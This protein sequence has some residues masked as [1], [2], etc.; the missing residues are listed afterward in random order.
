MEITNEIQEFDTYQ[1]MFAK[2]A[3]AAVATMGRTVVGV[4]Y[5]QGGR[6]FVSACLPV[7]VLTSLAR[8][9]SA[10]KKGDPAEARNRPLDNGHVKEITNY[11]TTE[12][13]YL[14][15]PIMLNS[16]QRL[17]IFAY[18]TPSAA[19]PCVFVLPFDADLY[20]TDGQHRL[21]AL[22]RAAESRQDLRSDS[23]GVT[24]VEEADMDKVHQD[25]FDAAQVKP[26]AQ[27]LLV[28]YDGR[29]PINRMAKEIINGSPIFRGRIERI[30]SVGKNSLMMFTNNQV[31]Q[32]ILQL[33]VGDWSL[34]AD[35]LQKQAEEAITPASNLWRD[36][37]LSFFKGFTQANPQWSEVAERPLE[38][39]ITTDIPG[40]REHF[41][42]FTGGGLLVLSGIGHAILTLDHH[43]D[44]RLSEEQE[45]HIRALAELDWSRDSAIW[46]GSIVGAPGKITPHKANVVLA[47]ARAKARLGLPVTDKEGGAIE[48]ADALAAQ[49]EQELALIS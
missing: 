5:Q 35:A 21:E 3:E 38:L 30:G 36:K 4:F 32:A 12:S 44:G 17:Q 18:R 6:R 8:R 47:V 37:I 20:V 45:Q 23:V 16:S 40:L 9:D 24:I 2:A 10:T 48:R 27:A 14:V 31:K 33:V 43:P 42:H 7:P 28:E 11:L 25:F 22:K 1:D 49:Q 34:Y 29:E 19:K 46:A 39:G 41:L 26:L 15:P 13:E